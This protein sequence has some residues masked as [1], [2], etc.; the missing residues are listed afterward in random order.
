MQARRKLGTVEQ[1]L[2]EGMVIDEGEGLIER[3]RNHIV[4]WSWSRRFVGM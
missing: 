2:E 1:G 4:P 3:G